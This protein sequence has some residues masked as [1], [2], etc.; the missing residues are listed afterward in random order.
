VTTQNL[1]QEQL[2]LISEEVGEEKT[3]L[4]LCPAFQGDTSEY[5]N[6]TV[7]KIPKQ[8]LNKCEYGK[9]DYSLNVANLPMS[10]KPEKQSTLFD[11]GEEL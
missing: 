6:L 10:V 3:L 1:T 9:D 2:R 4:I 5:G 7:K 8:V 11:E